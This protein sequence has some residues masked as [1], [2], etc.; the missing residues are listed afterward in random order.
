MEEKYVSC[1]E[2]YFPFDDFEDS[3][4]DGD[5]AMPIPINAGTVYPERF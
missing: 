5:I 1:L 2:H 4:T 3:T